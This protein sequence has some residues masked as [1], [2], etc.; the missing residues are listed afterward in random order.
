MTLDKYLKLKVDIDGAT[1]MQCFFLQKNSDY[2]KYVSK[3]TIF[4]GK[5]PIDFIFFIFL[6]QDTNINV[7]VINILHWF[8]IIN[9]RNS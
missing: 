1:F 9:S 2:M 7:K 5:E 6:T 4:Q 8:R 3:A